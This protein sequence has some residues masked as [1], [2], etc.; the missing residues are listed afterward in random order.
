MLAKSEIRSPIDGTITA[1]FVHPGQIIEPLSRVATVANL[2]QTRL[3]AEVSEF[4]AG[5]VALG[6]SATVTAEGWSSPGVKATGGFAGG[7]A[8]RRRAGLARR[9]LT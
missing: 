5:R 6:A 9:L 3:E 4:D 8:F 7:D 1:R 2:Q